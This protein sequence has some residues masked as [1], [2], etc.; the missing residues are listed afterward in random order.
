MT[1]PEDIAHDRAFELLPWFVNASLESDEH[2]AVRAHAS[3]CM[4]CRRE[5]AEL[6]DL[7][8]SIRHLP[9]DEA[10]PEPDMRRINARIDA[11]L[12]RERRPLRILSAL[13]DWFGSPF[14][15]A[16][17]AQT[18]ALLVIAVIWLQ[19]NETDPEFRTLTS[20]EPLPAGQYVRI[21]FDPNAGESAVAELLDSSGLILVSGPSERG[22]ATLRFAAD[23]GDNEH[24]DLIRRMQ[25][26]SRV[27]FAEAVESGE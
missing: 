23:T 18:I 13:R 21:V 17:A 20:T 5:I 15:I 7:Q 12:A 24:D 10:I 1:A 6:E 27:L 26:D 25:A 3:S 2:E 14:R 9:A 19:P 11:Q 22:V 4:I 8:R 16:F